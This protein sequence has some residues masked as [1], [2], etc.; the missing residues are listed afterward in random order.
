MKKIVRSGKNI[1]RKTKIYSVDWLRDGFCYRTTIECKWEDVLECKKVARVLGEMPCDVIQEAE[2]SV[3]Y[4]RYIE[5]E[6]EV[7]ERMLKFEN[8]ALPA[9]FDFF[10]LDSLSYEARE[11]LNRYHPTSIGQASRISGVSPADISVLLL[12][13]AK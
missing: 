2:V 12:N 8:I 6:C 9:S 5:K 4:Q 1:V 3:K 11:K 7:A 13:F 10:S